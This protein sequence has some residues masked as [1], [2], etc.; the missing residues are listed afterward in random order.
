M[1]YYHINSFVSPQ[2]KHVNKISAP[3]CVKRGTSWAQM[4]ILID[5][6]QRCMPRRSDATYHIYT[7][8]TAVYYRS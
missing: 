2:S 4:R 1:F 5:F 6:F 7:Y 8:T 3:F